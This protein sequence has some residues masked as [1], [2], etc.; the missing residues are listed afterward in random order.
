[1]TG[2][3]EENYIAFGARAKTFKVARVLAAERFA[4]E[5]ISHGGTGVV[6][7]NNSP[8]PSPLGSRPLHFRRAF[9]APGVV[10]RLPKLQ[11]RGR[12]YVRL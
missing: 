5:S 1:M 11:R 9:I 12:V 3:S 2:A 10:S 4:G 7:S 8:P 6:V